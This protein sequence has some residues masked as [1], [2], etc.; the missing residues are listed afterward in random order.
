M[1]EIQKELEK[2]GKYQEL[3]SFLKDN[4]PATLREVVVNKKP[5]P[6]HTVILRSGKDMVV[7]KHYNCA[8]LTFPQKLVMQNKDVAQLR[9]DVKNFLMDKM[10]Y[11]YI[12]VDDKAYIEY[13]KYKY[14]EE[15][16]QITK[17][18][19][20]IYRYRLRHGII[21]NDYSRNNPNNPKINLSQ[22]RPS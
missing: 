6:A 13:F 14:R 21:N 4:F 20:E 9:R 18:K 22:V 16:G 15:A 10:G 8:L 11:D 5:D 7:F 2:N 1:I 19:R 12:I 17:E 3:I